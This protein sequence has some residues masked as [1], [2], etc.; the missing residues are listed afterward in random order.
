MS[1]ALIEQLLYLSLLIGIVLR[2]GHQ[3]HHAGVAYVQLFWP[4]QPKLA[5]RINDLLLVGYYLVNVG[6]TLLL[7]VWFRFE[8]TS[9]SAM[10]ADLAQKVGGIVLV[11]GILH[12]NN[13]IWLY[14]LGRRA[15]LMS[16]HKPYKS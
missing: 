1:L 5:H 11:L 15:N 9:V 2:V 12:F 7:L 6:Y 10:C 3:L 16:H 13:M 8:P 4:T 14:L